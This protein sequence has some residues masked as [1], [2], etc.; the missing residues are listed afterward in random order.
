MR[1]RESP[2]PPTSHPNLRTETGDEI[3]GSKNAAS[4]GIA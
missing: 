3:V 2:M 4:G 1:L